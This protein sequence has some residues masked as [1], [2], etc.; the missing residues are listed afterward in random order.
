MEEY[1]ELIERLMESPNIQGLYDSYIIKDITFKEWVVGMVDD[2]Y[3]TKN[4]KKSDK[5][6]QWI[7]DSIMDKNFA[8]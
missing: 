5:I 3:M 8:D 1:N 2:V 7:T 6:G 4:V